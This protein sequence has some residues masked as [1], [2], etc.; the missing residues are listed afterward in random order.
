MALDEVVD[1][2][3]STF[4]RRFK[5][6]DQRW[7]NVENETKSGREQT[8]GLNVRQRRYYVSNALTTLYNVDTTLWNVE[9]RFLQRCTTSL[10]RCFIFDISY[11]DV[12][13]RWSQRCFKY[14]T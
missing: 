14:I 10:Q 5:V 2:T 9:Q 11:L 12:V 7:N 4:Q 8:L 3:Q 6:L 13:S 1:K